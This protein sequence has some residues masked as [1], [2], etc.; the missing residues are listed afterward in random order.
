MEAYAAFGRP[1][2]LGGTAQGFC[3]N[4]GRTFGSFPP[5]L[6]GFVSLNLPL[7]T[8]IVLFS[9][10]ASGTGATIGTR[11]GPLKSATT[12]QGTAA[13]SAATM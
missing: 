11:S 4:A 8:T 12:R 9:A 6:V 5:T 2:A 1:T 13:A 3:H 10:F 7:G